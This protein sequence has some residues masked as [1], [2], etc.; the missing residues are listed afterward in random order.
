MLEVARKGIFDCTSN[1]A[2][3]GRRYHTLKLPKDRFSIFHFYTKVVLSLY[4]FC[5][6]NRSSNTAKIEAGAINGSSKIRS[7][8]IQPAP[9]GRFLYQTTKR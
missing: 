6:L 1:A 7:E 3:S 2:F 8:K 5:K 9:D 4:I